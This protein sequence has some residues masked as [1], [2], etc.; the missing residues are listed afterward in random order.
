MSDQLSNNKR[1]IINTLL[2]YGRMILLMAVSL[3]TVREVLKALGVVDYGLYN[4]VG[5]IVVVFSFLSNTMLGASQR[6]FSY[7][8]GVGDKV[9]LKRTF[10][11]TVTI[12]LILSVIIFIIAE[13]LGLWFLNNKMNIPV[14]R[15][16]AC[17]YVFQFSVASFIISIL[18]IPYTSLLVA[19]ERLKYYA[20]IGVIE[21]VL[22]LLIV[23][24]LLVVDYDRL[25]LYS[26]LLFFV[27]T[28][29]SFIYYRTCR[30]NYIESKYEFVFD[31]TYFNKIL[32]FSGWNIFGALAGVMNNQGLNLIINI[33]FGAVIN[34]ARAIAIQINSVLNLFVSNL[35]LSIRP[36]I[37]KY[38]AQNEHDQMMIL[39]FQ[40]SKISFY[41]LTFLSIPILI[42]IDQILYYWLGD[43]QAYVVLFIR[44][45]IAT[46]L[47]DCISYPLM[48]A[49]QATGNIKKYQ[50]ILGG[51]I[52][53]NIPITYF[54]YDYGFSPEIGLYVI[55][56][57]SIICLF[58]RLWILNGLIRLNIY[59]YI[60]KV[61]VKIILV[62]AI[63]YSI[64][65]FINSFFDKNFLS[66]IT[67]SFISCLVTLGIIY[68]MGLNNIERKYISEFLKRKLKIKTI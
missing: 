16:I 27:S 19:Y 56:I 2:L 32:S 38:Y 5:G 21:A 28:V 65:L 23:Y 3:F 29:N 40:S 64:I 31:K 37:T 53:L 66:L 62:F 26:A 17:N 57:T 42:N 13:T 12:Y 8:I 41:L 61:V 60:T 44:I 58:L 34:S 11:I 67:I 25:I 10:S 30:K 46:T 35:M 7:D 33:F 1:I 50:L 59:E 51:T 14:E 24:V 47:V 20:Y 6:F 48:T 52:L 45:T 49:A 18:T 54:L 9:K 39:V 43:I 15:L 68:I 36:Q 55:F 4:V 63:S 22:K